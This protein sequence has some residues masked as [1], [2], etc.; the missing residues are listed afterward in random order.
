MQGIVGHRHCFRILANRQRAV[1]RQHSVGIEHNVFAM[2]ASELWGLDIE[3]IAANGQ[4]RQGIV[5]ARVGVRLVRNPCAQLS[6][7]D[8]G[9]GHYA[10]RRVFYRARNAARNR[11]PGSADKQ[12]EAAGQLDYKSAIRARTYHS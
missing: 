3:L 4:N 5:A 10:S 11:S 6:R 7:R 1:D 9:V 12:Q 2:I 8:I